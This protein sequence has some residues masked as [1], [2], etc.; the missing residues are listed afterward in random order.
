MMIINFINIELDNGRFK[1]EWN[2]LSALNKLM[3][4]GKEKVF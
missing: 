2:K 3:M 1:D 4:D